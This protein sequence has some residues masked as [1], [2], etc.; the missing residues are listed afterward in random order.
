M[1]ERH[2]YSYLRG[3]RQTGW[4]LTAACAVAALLNA[5]ALWL[6][7][8]LFS[9]GLAAASLPVA[10][11]QGWLGL[12]LLRSVAI[13]RRKLP[14]LLQSDPLA[15]KRLETDRTD[16]DLHNL[17]QRRNGML[18]L[19]LL[20]LALALIGSVGEKGPFPLGSGIGL[21]LQSAILLMIDLFSGLRL[22][23]YRHFLQKES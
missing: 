2:L 4:G 23:L 13:W 5:L 7:P 17:Q 19:W 14:E 21:A 8:G 6:D 3:Q 16:R 1:E 22:G 9:F 15:F 12:S 10:G 18:T 11:V 20:G